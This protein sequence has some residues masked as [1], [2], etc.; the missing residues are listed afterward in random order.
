M[1]STFSQCDSRPEASPPREATLLPGKGGFP[2]GH[3]VRLNRMATS[4][5]SISRLIRVLLAVSALLVILPSHVRG[6]AQ[7][8]AQGESTN[9]ITVT[10]ARGVLTPSA[11]RVKPGFYSFRLRNGFVV[12][13]VTFELVETTSKKAQRV[14]IAPGKAKGQLTYHLT[15]G[16][17]QLSVLEVPKAAST[18]TVQ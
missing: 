17:Y 2:V 14:Q 6:Q 9:Y 11:V 12:G 10:L 18:I 13:V 1:M 4:C 15:P 7:Q 16:Q 5:V 3:A 8:A